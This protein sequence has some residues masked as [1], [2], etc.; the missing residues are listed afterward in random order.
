[1]IKRQIGKIQEVNFGHCGYQ[2]CC[3]GIY[4]SLGSEKDSWGVSDSW[5][6]WYLERSDSAKW[7]ENGRLKRLG[8]T[9]M[10]IAKLLEDA[11]VTNI[12]DLIGVPVEV[13]FDSNCLKSWRILTEVI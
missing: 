5:G 9:C 13:T 10:D 1:M 4:F 2:D 3:I 8:K 6:D 7:T 12:T 11:K